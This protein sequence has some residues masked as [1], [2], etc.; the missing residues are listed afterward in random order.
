M[1]QHMDLPLLQRS[2]NVLHETTHC[3]LVHVSAMCMNRDPSICSLFMCRLTVKTNTLI[4]WL[5][6]L[7][8]FIRGYER[9]Q[10]DL[11]GV[12]SRP[13]PTTYHAPHLLLRCFRVARQKSM[14]RKSVQGGAMK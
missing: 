1:K 11:I 12:M 4:S 14:A 13:N 3:I 8:G 6:I 10:F 2:Y 9:F 7:V 5:I